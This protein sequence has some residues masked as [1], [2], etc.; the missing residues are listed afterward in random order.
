MVF[1]LLVL[2]IRERERDREEKVN[3]LRLGV[4]IID[5][6]IIV[7]LLLIGVGDG[8][9]I[10]VGSRCVCRPRGGAI[11][12]LTCDK[13]RV[14]AFYLLVLEFCFCFRIGFCGIL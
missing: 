8:D 6:N 9:N 3:R 10:I 1:L 13:T 7:I 11:P 4:T 2:L 5:L 14:L 12:V